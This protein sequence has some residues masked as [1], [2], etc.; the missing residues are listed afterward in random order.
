MPSSPSQYTCCRACVPAAENVH[1]LILCR[2]ID[3]H[4]RVYPY[5]PMWVM[6]VQQLIVWWFEHF[7]AQQ[8]QHFMEENRIYGIF[9]SAYHAHHSGE[10]ALVRIHK[11]IAQSID[12]HRSVL[13]VLLV[14]SAAFDTINHNTLLRRLSGHGLSGDVLAWLTSYLCYR[15]CVVRVKSGVLEVETMTIGVPKGTVIGPLLCNTYIAPLTTLLQKHNIHHHLYADDTQLYITFSPTD[16]TQ[17]RAYGILRTRCE[18]MALWQC[19]CDQWQQIARHCLP[20]VKSTYVYIVNPRQHMWPPRW[21][22]PINTGP[23]L[24]YWH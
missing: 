22:F 8:L 6:R 4:V 13:P 24:Y 21:H 17:A 15:T 3:G 7:V 11:D 14:L 2:H 18:S 19:T 9:Q 16:Q 5:L 20:F 1:K 10:A 12:S 23:M